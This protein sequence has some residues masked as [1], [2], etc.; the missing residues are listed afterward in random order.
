MTVDEFRE[1]W[2]QSSADPPAFIQPRS[3]GVENEDQSPADDDFDVEAQ[4]EFLEEMVTD[5]ALEEEI[6]THLRNQEFKEMLA[7]VDGTQPSF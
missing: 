5:R 2:F 6:N 3:K 7:R 1:I 4:A